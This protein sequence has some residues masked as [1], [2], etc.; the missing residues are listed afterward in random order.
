[1]PPLCQ[2][3]LEEAEGRIEVLVKDARG[4]AA[5]DRF[6]DVGWSE[7]PKHPPI[8]L[9]FPSGDRAGSAADCLKIC[10]RNTSD[11]LYGT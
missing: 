1:M 4:E 5:L 6:V 8:V 9:P 2:A 10:V 3:R 7:L 11:G